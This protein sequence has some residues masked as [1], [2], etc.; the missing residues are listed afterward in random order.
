MTS[1]VVSVVL[2]TYCR[3]RL[4]RRAIRSVLTQTYPYV[5]VCVYDNASTDDSSSVV[6]ELAR[7]DHRIVYHRHSRN[8][9]AAA[10]FIYGLERVNTKY[11]SILS[12]DDILLPNL[13]ESAVADLEKHPQAGFAAFGVLLQ[14]PP[15]DFLVLDRSM[16]TC[17]EGLYESQDRI[18]TVA[19][20][21]PPLWTGTLFR[22]SL[23]DEIGMVQ[24]GVGAAFDFD[25]QFRASARS[26][27][28]I[29]HAPGAVFARTSIFIA[30]RWLSN[31]DAFWPGWRILM[32][33]LLDDA[34]ISPEVRRELR[35]LLLNLLTEYLWI[36]GC[37]CILRG[38]YA[39][40]HKAADILKAELREH[41]RATTLHGLSRLCQGIPVLRMFPRSLVYLR[42][43]YR[44][45]REG[46]ADRYS[47]YRPILDAKA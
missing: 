22:K 13:L 6:A 20:E 9:G 12:D 17:P 41:A 24:P 8:I 29:R 35:P 39:E 46:F 14:L 7:A 44:R 36:V 37:S 28:L 26:P 45:L 23:L 16:Q 43:I 32:G 31:V 47:Q 2:P 40:A 3:A 19:R 21:K 38:E 30:D 1:P 42:T 4:L 34:R 27:F 15:W 10:N 33:N 11:F 18:L 5:Q 25:F